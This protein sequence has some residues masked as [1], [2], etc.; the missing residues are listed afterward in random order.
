ML[1]RDVVTIALLSRPFFVW[2]LTLILFSLLSF[3]IH[4][5][6]DRCTY[7]YRFEDRNDVPNADNLPGAKISNDGWSFQNYDGISH[8]SSNSNA[9]CTFE[10]ELDGP[11]RYDFRWGLKTS[12]TTHGLFLFYE[13][14]KAPKS[15]TGE[16]SIGPIDVDSLGKH[17]L[18]WVVS[19]S[20]E[21][22]YVGLLDELNIEKGNCIK[23]SMVLSQPL[24]PS[25]PIEGETNKRYKFSAEYEDH[26]RDGI[27]YIFDWDD[28][29]VPE[30][31]PSASGES[32]WAEHIWTQSGLY[33]VKVRSIFGGSLSN[34][35]ESHTIKIF[36]LENVSTGVDLNSIIKNIG[37][38]TKVQLLGDTYRG[39]LILENKH[40]ILI[41]S[42]INTKL[43][44]DDCRDFIIGLENLSNFTLEGFQI[45]N[46]ISQCAIYL[47]MC[48]DCSILNNIVNLENK[49]IGI[50]DIAGYNNSIE[51][52]II[53]SNNTESC[54][55][56]NCSGISV[57][58]TVK[59]KIRCN[60]IN[61]DRQSYIYH[62]LNSSNGS[63]LKIHS[64]NQG[65]IFVDRCYS[66]L[67]NSG[68]NLWRF[69]N[70]SLCRGI[71]YEIC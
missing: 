69:R 45:M 22:D 8:F 35:S 70:G 7:S 54:I 32:A 18:R 39:P 68:N 67:S 11:F 38:Y 51:N 36:Q 28:G 71:E 1:G 3:N 16:D 25:G 52:N 64:S 19:K 29:S 21:E 34:W 61:G 40:D 23:P 4:G 17:K 58:N 59:V 14:K 63:E 43:I 56:N 12:G 33:K 27:E 53:N 42:N 50:S 20:K 13:D 31:E 65:K 62:F 24:K 55:S 41:R 10:I 46:N 57:E 5:Q 66:Y 2:L 15:C 47:D 60:K 26:I 44:C 30:I 9:F 49:I 48:R 6:E 37:N